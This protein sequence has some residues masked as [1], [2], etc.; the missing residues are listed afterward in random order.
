MKQKTKNP[1]SPVKKKKGRV[2]VRYKLFL[3]F[4]VF[5]VLILTILWL[6]QVI[7]L[8][9]I[10]KTVKLSELRI[11]ARALSQRITDENFADEAEL[12][13]SRGDMCI[14]V[15]HM[16]NDDTALEVVSI[17]T[18]PFCMIHNTDRNSKFT[19]YD[20][21]RENGG[22]LLRHFRFDGENHMYYSVDEAPEDLSD[23]NEY[24]LYTILT[25]K[26]GE[27][28]MFM[29]NSIIS[30]V[31]ATTRTLNYIL[32][33]VSLLLLILSAVFALIISR[34][35]TRPIVSIN[36]SA[37]QLAAGD[38]KVR[39]NEGGYR[40]ISELA[41]TLN[42]AA[43]ELGKVD[44][45]RRELI[46]NISH[47]LRTPL[48]MIQGYAELMRDIPGE[49]T[50]ENE[51]IVI[52]ETQRLTSL[53][54]DMLDLS[55]YE[56]GNQSADFAECNITVIIR[57]L[58]TRYNSFCEKDGYRLEFSYDEELTMY[59]DSTKLVQA[60]YNLVNNAITYTGPDKIV[61]VGQYVALGQDGKPLT[62]RFT[63]K[64][65]G[66]GIPADKLESIWERY[67]K[68]D[69]VHRRASVGTGLGLSIV[70]NIAQ[71]LGGSCGVESEIGKGST[72]WI[73][74]PVNSVG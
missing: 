19:F 4:A 44:G 11:S 12:L 25:E 69:K 34:K 8:P 55:K 32:I 17:D 39:F 70:K 18:L 31:S 68:V 41:D 49:N 7:F 61:R 72:F 36:D 40:E 35:F 56:S 43:D 51:Q 10:Y 23:T 54:N 1:A 52:D 46:A 66:E 59:T 50:P 42:Y 27:T 62:A 37:K 16:L 14:L 53:V 13:A 21:A 9:D 63:V 2:G 47:D 5:T 60:V 38:Y 15:L 64:D 65:S 57:D 71:L 20:L 58:L 30:P 45:L 24:I 29:L 67:Y 74:L 33:A 6:T 28:Y 3:Y 48:T 26:D 73:E 22:E